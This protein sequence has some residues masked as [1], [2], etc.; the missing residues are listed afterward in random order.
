MSDEEYVEVP[1]R[2]P[3][4]KKIKIDP[5]EVIKICCGVLQ[6]V[7]NEEN[8]F[9]KYIRKANFLHLPTRMAFTIADLIKN[10]GETVDK[11]SESI[12]KKKEKLPIV[13]QLKKIITDLQVQRQDLESKLEYSTNQNRKNRASSD[14]N[15]G[16]VEK[17]RRDN[18]MLMDKLKEQL[19]KSAEIKYRNHSRE[20][21]IVELQKTRFIISKEKPSTFD[22]DDTDEMRMEIK[23]LREQLTICKRIP[24][25]EDMF[26]KSNKRYLY[27]KQMK[28]TWEKQEQERRQKELEQEEKNIKET[29]PPCE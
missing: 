7:K 21:L 29:K 12:E 8:N 16:L 2:P 11:I 15:K 4:V 23:K 26:E 28:P 24:G 5:E 27:D 1:V 3:R 17:L 14:L 18:Q 10:S 13:E 9:K 25:F 6:F 22:I 20:D 19:N